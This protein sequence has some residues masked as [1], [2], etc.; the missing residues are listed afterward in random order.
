MCTP[1]YCARG[2]WGVLRGILADGDAPR[3]SEQV[4]YAGS[5]LSW[6]LIWLSVLGHF[7]EPVCLSDVRNSFIYENVITFSGWIVD[8]G[9]EGGGVRTTLARKVEFMYPARSLLKKNN[10]LFTERFASCQIITTKPSSIARV[11]I[12]GANCQDMIT[13]FPGVTAHLSHLVTC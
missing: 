2:I 10:F 4:S 7:R 3:T 8:G 5:F 1:R 9:S 6:D 13:P 11:A 12:S